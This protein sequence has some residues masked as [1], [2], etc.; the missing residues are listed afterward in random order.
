VRQPL[1]GIWQMLDLAQQISRAVEALG[2]LG[3]AGAT[4][5]S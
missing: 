4:H 2:F 3:V 1:D 5:M